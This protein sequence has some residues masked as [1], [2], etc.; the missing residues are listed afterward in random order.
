LLLLCDFERSQVLLELTLL[1]AVLV[2][3]VFEG[4]LLLFFQRGK[5]I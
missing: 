1:D 4:D 5:L 3:R 2:L